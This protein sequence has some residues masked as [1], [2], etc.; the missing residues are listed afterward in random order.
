MTAP[1]QT[2]TKEQV[3]YHCRIGRGELDRLFRI[4]AEGTAPGAIKLSTTHGETQFD[5]DT[6]DDL[7][8]TREVSNLVSPNDPWEYLEFRA[9]D[10]VGESRN[11]RLLISDSDVQLKVFGR[12]AIWVHGQF[13]RLQVLLT[14]M[15]A[16][17]EPR[18]HRTIAKIWL[19]F[20]FLILVTTLVVSSSVDDSF[21]VGSVNCNEAPKQGPSGNGGIYAIW[22]GAVIWILTLAKAVHSHAG[23]RARRPIF[24][25]TEQIPC[26]NL[27]ERLTVPDRIGF[28]AVIIAGLSLVVTVA[29]LLIS[30]K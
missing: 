10:P 27:W 21:G 2:T 22:A 23:L 1:T 26:G 17:Y 3:F 6:L 13:A 8:A 5:G 25:V 15:G 24:R 20:S 7:I 14:G 28:A 16:E 19:T 30:G 9:H 29:P 11:V 12:D 18:S 4:A